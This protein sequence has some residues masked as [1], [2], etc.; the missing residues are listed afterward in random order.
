MPNSEQ[1]KA[2]DNMLYGLLLEKENSNSICSQCFASWQTEKKRLC[3]RDFRVSKS[4]R[5]TFFMEAWRQKQLFAANGT[6]KRGSALVLNFSYLLVNQLMLMVYV[7]WLVRCRCVYIVWKCAAWD[8]CGFHFTHATNE[9]T[10]ERA[11][12]TS[13]TATTK[14]LARIRLHCAN[15][16]SC[17]KKEI[18]LNRFTSECESIF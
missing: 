7:F 8:L 13:T 1:C 15:L 2:A 12:N 18:W 11:N 9:Q 6:K 3:V 4:G 5:S 10:S 14:K 16:K 17:S